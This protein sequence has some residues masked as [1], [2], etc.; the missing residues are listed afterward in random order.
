MKLTNSNKK[1]RHFLL[2]SKRFKIR[3]ICV[4]IVKIYIALTTVGY[5]TDLH[6]YFN[7]SILKLFY[8]NHG[9]IISK[10]S[11]I[12]TVNGIDRN[13]KIFS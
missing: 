13:I 11:N 2:K 12:N 4:F 7:L 8:C 1:L 5:K 10:N 9:N 6:I 3:N